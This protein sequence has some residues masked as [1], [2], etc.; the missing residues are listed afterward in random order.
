MIPIVSVVGKSN[1][2]K[3]TLI[4]KMIEKLVEKGYRVATIK[5]NLHGF[6][7]DHEGKD[8]WRY[9]K[10]GARLTLLASPGKVAVIE[11]TGVD[12]GIGELRDRYI[13]NVDI[14]L[15][16]GFKG[17]PYPKIEVFRSVMKRELLS[18]EDDNLIAIASDVPLETDANLF[19]I[20][21]IE[22]ITDMVED[23]FLS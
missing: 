23:L 12:L 8:S 5:H 2:G 22:G 10:A 14:I 15:T 9:K 17:N 7:I 3:T 20:N 11:D 16:E 18:S 1:S 4:E 13:N 6:D 19:D 21:D